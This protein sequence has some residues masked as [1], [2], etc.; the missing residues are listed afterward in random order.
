MRPPLQ[1]IVSK[2]AKDQRC[3]DQI[4]LDTGGVTYCEGSICPVLNAKLLA[5]E[6]S[7]EPALYSQWLHVNTNSPNSPSDQDPAWMDVKDYIW[8]EEL[9]PALK[10][11]SYGEQDA[12]LETMSKRFLSTGLV[13]FEEP[14]VALNS[15]TAVYVFSE[16]I[17]FLF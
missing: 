7:S 6:A 8:D 2:Y 1:N 15:Y 14:D 9:F 5:R 3:S 4:G 13:A 16:F 10:T 17:H 12:K 11:L